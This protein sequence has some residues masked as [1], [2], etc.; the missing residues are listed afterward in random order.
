[1]DADF[2]AILAGHAALTNLVSTRIYPVQYPQAAASPAV[3]YTVINAAPGLH[4]QGSDGLTETLMQIDVRATTFASSV[5][6]RDVLVALLHPYRG[7]VGNTDF[8]LIRLSS[9][10]GA[11]FEKPANF[12]Y[13]TTSLDFQIWSRAAA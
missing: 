7:L 3:R 2:R 5:A 4:M 11:Q 12:E 10:R 1:M 8:R 6:I 13:F 9:D